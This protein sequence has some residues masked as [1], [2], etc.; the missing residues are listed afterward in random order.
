[1]ILM[2]TVKNLRSKGLFHIFE[3]RRLPE[4]SP[5]RTIRLNDRIFVVRVYRAQA[6]TDGPHPSVWLSTSIC[7]SGRMDGP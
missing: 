1:M 5:D 3:K 6:A 7:T 2:K 4:R